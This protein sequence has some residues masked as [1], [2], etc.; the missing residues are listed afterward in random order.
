MKQCIKVFRL[1]IVTVVLF[2]ASTVY[3]SEQQAV[4]VGFI[5]ATVYL[6]KT[7]GSYLLNFDSYFM[8]QKPGRIVVVLF[9]YYDRNDN[10]LFLRRLTANPPFEN[11]GKHMGVFKPEG[12]FV[13]HENRFDEG[14]RV[15]VAHAFEQVPRQ[16][17]VRQ[18][19]V[20]VILA[21]NDNTFEVVGMDIP[22]NEF[23]PDH[24]VYP[25]FK[26]TW[27]H[28][29]SHDLHAHHRQIYYPVNS[30]YFAIDFMKIDINGEFIQPGTDGSK[31]SDYYTYGQPLVSPG[32][33]T[34][35]GLVDRFQDAP[36]GGRADDFDP[37]C[38]GGNY[39]MIR[40]RENLY[41]YLAHIKL[42]SFK[43]EIGDTVTAG[44]VLALCGNSGNSDAPHIH[45][46]HVPEPT[47][48]ILKV[49]GLPIVFREFHSKIGASLFR[50]L[51]RGSF[52]GE[53]LVNE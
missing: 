7:S 5:P 43:V 11:I 53:I 40:H 1:L 29:Q 20:Q 4:K 15:F 6:E 30:N 38:P 37:E 31:L 47:N 39:I 16:Y 17:R 44:Q 35:V 48:A 12:G 50:N 8:A 13:P 41:S 2:M 21:Y 9:R 3:G 18:V 52:P 34:V 45:F 42:N 25:P 22:V 27:L 32:D 23:R 51:N 26:G 36:M 14:D 49:H 19:K 33:G 24:D 10:L 46:H 28:M